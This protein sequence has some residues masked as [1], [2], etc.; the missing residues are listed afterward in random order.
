LHEES[1]IVENGG[2]RDLIFQVITSWQVIAVTLVILF[3]I[4]LVNYVTRN[5]S[6]RRRA[7]ASKPKKEKVKKAKAPEEAVDDSELGLED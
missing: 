4:S 7:A 3:Y 1:T 6:V 5:R 2:L